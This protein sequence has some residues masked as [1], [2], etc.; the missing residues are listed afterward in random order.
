MFRLLIVDDEVVIANGI[1]SSINW[2][3]LGFTK[4]ETAFN[5]R[6]AKEAFASNPF[7]VMICDIEMPQGTGFD[8]FAWVRENHPNTECIFLTCHAEF[9]FAKKAIQLGS[10]DYLLKPV[11]EEELKKTIETALIKIRR[12]REKTVK[13]HEHFWLE[14]LHQE[15]PARADL[16]LQQAKQLDLAY[17]EETLFL[18]VLIHHDYWDKKLEEHDKHILLYALRNALDELVLNHLHASHSVYLNDGTYMIILPLTGSIEDHFVEEVK[19]LCEAYV[20]ACKTYFYSHLSCYI[21]NTIPLERIASMYDSL[22]QFQR[23]QANTASKVFFINKQ[24][25][26]DYKTTLPNMQVWLEMLRRQE[27]ERLLAEISS[28]FENWKGIENLEAKR[29]QLFYQSFLQIVLQALKEIGLS[30]EEIMHEHLD[31]KR[32]MNATRSIWEMQNWAIEA[33]EIAISS[34]KTLAANETIVEKIQ[35]YIELHLDEELSRQY[36]ADFVGLSPDH[37]VKL[38]KKEMGLS[39]SDYI[40][41]KRISRAKELLLKTDMTISDV[42]ISVGYT[43]FSYFSTLFRKE[44]SMT[45]QEFRRL[46]TKSK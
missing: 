39:I 3:G 11:L 8:L 33:I 43:N 37:V 38:F 35:R 2:R 27:K 28:H 25:Q 18:T 12:D 26:M 17:T 45:P 1:K 19:C 41:E 31:L 23:S 44:T 6:Q 32:L 29:L 13:L 4:V 20:E 5:M 21:G 30:A 9:E 7:D 36:V 34:M 14:I 22:S 24:P 40:L 16:I 15:I 10:L 46:K 42:A